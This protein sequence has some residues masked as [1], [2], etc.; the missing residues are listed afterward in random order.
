MLS[1]KRL[2]FPS[3]KPNHMTLQD[4]LQ[5]ENFKFLL[6][7]Q[8]STQFLL[9]VKVLDVSITTKVHFILKQCGKIN[10]QKKNPQFSVIFFHCTRIKI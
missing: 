4:L 10:L 5:D 3:E 7:P 1:L 9:E 8:G 6:Y 2:I